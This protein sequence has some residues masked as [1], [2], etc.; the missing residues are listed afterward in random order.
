MADPL[1]ELL[2]SPECQPLLSGL[3]R[4]AERGK[5]LTG[6]LQLADLTQEQR[7]AISETTGQACRGSRTSIDLDAF[8]QIV[9]GTRR[10]RSLLELLEAASGGTIENK[11]AARQ[12][13]LAEWDEL[14]CW[15]DQATDDP[16]CRTWLAGLRKTGWLKARTRRDHVAAKRMLAAALAVL[17]KLP[18][19]GVPLPV[20]AS[21]HLGDAHALD[22]DRDLGR[23]V[24]RAVAATHDL[25]APERRR[26]F[27]KTW[28][29]V[30]VVP[31]EL[32]VTALALNLPAT[33]DSLTDEML[34]AHA[35]RGEPCRVTFRHLRL[36]A[37]QFARPSDGPLYVCENP[38]IVAS[39]AERLA[40]NSRPLVCLEGQPNLAALRLLHLAGRAGW[41]LAYHGDFDWGGIRIANQ[42]FQEIGFTPWR[43]DTKNYLT[44]AGKRRRLSSA[45]A[46]A[47][48]DADLAAAMKCR[49]HALD[50]EQVVD[51]LL[52]DLVKP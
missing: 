20:F 26:D 52:R 41:I 2:K 21:A 44:A 45:P 40:V 50:E 17:E 6:T 43:F 19:D 42:L 24:C 22:A 11:A 49:G 16:R 12:R 5:P 8:A 39:A 3:G 27:R 51:L 4:R 1:V 7:R 23:L 33:G 25:R 9:C 29:A 37:P 13:H 31:D 47:L 36:H 10:F 34:R 15:A 30:G 18:A 32:S 46:D 28:E 38:S 48:W 14:W 35:A